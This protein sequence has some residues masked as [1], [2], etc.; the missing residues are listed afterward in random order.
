MLEMEERRET[1]RLEIK[2][3]IKKGRG[4]LGLPLLCAVQHM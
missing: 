1:E 4:K 3:I 2:Q